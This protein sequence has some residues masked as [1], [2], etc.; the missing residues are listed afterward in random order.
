MPWY[1][2][3]ACAAMPSATFGSGSTPFGYATR[4]PLRTQRH[5]AI[6]GGAA[7]R[8]RGRV[9]AIRGERVRRRRHVAAPPVD[10]RVRAEA[11]HQIEPVVAGGDRED[12]RAHALREL[13]REVTDAAA[14]AEDDEGLPGTRGEELEAREGGQ[15]VRGEGAGRARGHRGGTG[16]TSSS[17]RTAYSA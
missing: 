15:A 14:R 4:P 8:G 10:G 3:K 11:P 1:P 16:E 2:S 13:Q 7:G 17:G 6:G 12:A 9:E 5:R